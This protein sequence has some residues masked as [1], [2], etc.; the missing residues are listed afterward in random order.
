MSFLNHF[1][2]ERQRSEND[3]LRFVAGQVRNIEVAA[4]LRGMIPQLGLAEEA[5]DVVAALDQRLDE[6]SARR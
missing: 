1:G 2:Y 5:K 6:E 3:Y 4:N